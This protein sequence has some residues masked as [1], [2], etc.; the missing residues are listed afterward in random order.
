MKKKI[1]TGVMM[2]M[3]AMSVTACGA[4]KADSAVTA[5]VNTEAQPQEDDK[6][7]KE[8]FE[9][10]DND[11]KTKEE[12]TKEEETDEEETEEEKT[13]E[14]SKESNNKE[15]KKKNDKSEISD[16]WEDM[17]FTMDGEFYALPMTFSVLEDEGWEINTDVYDDGDEVEPGDTKV[18][19]IYND[20]YDEDLSTFV[21]VTNYGKSTK[22]LSDCVIRNFSVDAAF[23][24]ELLKD[25]PEIVVAQGI[26]WGSTADEV[27]EAFGEPE[28]IYEAESLGYVT[29]TYEND[30]EDC[31]M[32][33]MIFENTG[34]TEIVIGTR[35]E[36]PSS[37]SGH[38]SSSSASTNNGGKK[39]DAD[40]SD[41]W[42]DMEFIFDGEKY[43]LEDAPY[44]TLQ[45]S[46]WDFDLADYGYEDG[47]V[48]NPNDQISG[49][50]DLS[51]PDYNEDLDVSVGFI[52]R[53]K[54]IKDIKECSI[55]SFDCSIEYGTELLDN[56]PDMT[57]AQGITWGSTAEEVIEAFGEPD[58]EY[59]S[60]ALGYTEYT[61]EDDYDKYLRIYV[62]DDYGVTEIQMKLY[63]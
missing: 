26:T 38:S 57:I 43:S 60:D 56:V 51:N 62:Y 45:E 11:A 49:T 4:E 2:A 13:E 44:A 8:M 28:S 48:L 52:N 7:L 22:S 9:E 63:E 40:I 1:L 24:D 15:E 21:S 27:V 10:K 20:D 37:T 16:D 42:K 17:Q 47:Y 32:E 36:K 3:I 50:V 25:I 30:D 55:W 35:K 18:V 46:G 29:Y 59:R 6:G 61:Y 34:V 33:F 41:D 23:A 19:C 58:D 53:T 5:E 39:K 54:K 12:K 31:E 14:E